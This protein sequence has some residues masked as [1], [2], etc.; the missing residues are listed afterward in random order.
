M[1]NSHPRGRVIVGC[2]LA[3]LVA[4]WIGG[5]LAA[6]AMTA[7]QSS[8]KV[9]FSG[10]IVNRASGKALDVKDKSTEDGANIQQWEFAGALNQLWEVID[11]GKG[12]YSIINRASGRGLDVADRS[13]ADGANIQQYRFANAPNQR[14]RLEEAG[15]YYRIVSV[16][17]RKCLDVDAAH[18][19]ENGANVQQW[20]C[21]G[22]AN[23]QWRLVAK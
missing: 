18:V 4:A 15:S 23:Q 11:Q 20:S 12:E 2:A 8:G 5:G 13:T 10:G 6:R 9:F 3:L 7:D 1:K 16:S 21:G 14:W 22:A 17:S 19:A